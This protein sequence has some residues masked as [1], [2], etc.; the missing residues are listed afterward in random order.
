METTILVPTP[1]YLSASS[2]SNPESIAEAEAEADANADY[3]EGG[4]LV[5]PPEVESNKHVD[6]RK[7]TK[8][9]SIPLKCPELQIP[10]KQPTQQQKVSQTGKTGEEVSRWLLMV[11]SPSGHWTIS[12]GA[13]EGVEDACHGLAGGDIGQPSARRALDAG[14]SCYVRTGDCVVVI[15]GAEL[16]LYIVVAAASHVVAV[17]AA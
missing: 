6:L 7:G 4:A 3:E 12:L 8:L 5:L 2:H 16:Y 10:W 13:E 1:L 9:Q 11:A 15:R 17:A 14:S